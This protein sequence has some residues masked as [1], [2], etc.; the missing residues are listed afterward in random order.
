MAAGK[1]GVSEAMAMRMIVSR[2]K[3]TVDS[4]RGGKSGEGDID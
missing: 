3:V 1:H 4:T 2:A